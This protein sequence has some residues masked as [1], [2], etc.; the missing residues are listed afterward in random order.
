[1]HSC[2]EGLCLLA[3]FVVASRSGYSLQSLTL[4]SVMSQIIPIPILPL[5]KRK[6]HADYDVKGLQYSRC[7]SLALANCCDNAFCIIKALLN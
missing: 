2:I 3:G 5:H 7:M 1:M 6:D 4:P